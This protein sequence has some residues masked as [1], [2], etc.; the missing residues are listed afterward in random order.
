MG[1]LTVVEAIGGFSIH[2]QPERCQENEEPTSLLRESRSRTHGTAARNV[3]TEPR[4][5]VYTLGDAGMDPRSRC[6]HLIAERT[7]PTLT[8]VCRRVTP[9]FLLLVFYS[10][11][12]SEKGILRGMSLFDNYT[13]KGFFD[14]M[15]E[16]D[17]RPH[18]HCRKLFQRLSE[19]S[20]PD[21]I[22]RV[23]L[24]D[25]MLVN[26]G[27]TFTVYGDERGTEKPWPFDLIPRIIPAD[28]WEHHRARP[29]AAADRPQP[30]PARRLPRPEDPQRPASCR[31]NLI[32]SAPHF[33]PRVV[34][35]RPA[36]RHLRP[37]LRQRPDPGQRRHLLRAG[38]QS[39]HARPASPTC[40]KTGRS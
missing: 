11:S 12:H 5:A 10:W 15:L 20:L 23:Q 2:A 28:E 36:R 30:V 21:F 29:D 16:P 14:E 40:C 33:R 8:S 17:G 27:I 18:A 39:A 1:G 6:S 7:S 13:A 32:V 26:Q 31:A 22:G 9:G 38:R 37:Y 3:L 25:L 24:A 35:A 19:M 34:W 4:V